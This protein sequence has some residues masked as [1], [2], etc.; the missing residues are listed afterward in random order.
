MNNIAAGLLLALAGVGSSFA[1]TITETRVDDTTFWHQSKA[2]FANLNTGHINSGILLDYGMEFA[3][4]ARFNGQDINDSNAVSFATLEQINSTLLSSQVAFSDHAP[5]PPATLYANLRAGARHNH[6]K[7]SGLLYEYQQLDSTQSAN[8]TIGAD[9]AYQDKYDETNTWLNPYKTGY[10]FAMALPVTWITGS[11]FTVELPENLWQTNLG[12]SVAQIEI[13]A[14]DGLG[15]RATA[16][17]GSLEV[18]YAA[19]GTKN[20][21]FR[22][23]V[24]GTGVFTGHG[25]VVVTQNATA[26]RNFTFTGTETYGDTVNSAEI[27]IDYAHN[28]GMLHKPLIIVEGIDP[29]DVLAPESQW[30]MTDVQA[31]FERDITNIQNNFPS[32]K[33]I[34]ELSS[35]EYDLI[36]VDW[37]NGT[38]YI[39]RNAALLKDLVKWVNDPAN[40]TGSEP[41]V[42]WGISMGGLVARYAIKDLEDDGYDHNI[43]LF[44]SDDAPQLGANVPLGAQAMCAHLK[45][46]FV[47]TGLLYQ[48]VANQIVPVTG[49][50]LAN[51]ALSLAERPA[52]AEMLINQYSPA[53]LALHNTWQEKLKQKGYPANCRNVVV[54]NG[55]ECAISQQ[56]NLNNELLSLHAQA[57]TG[58]ASDLLITSA[59]IIAPTLYALYASAATP[60]FG[61]LG[62]SPFLALLPGSSSI[63][64]DFDINPSLDGGYN[65]LYHGKLKYT[66]K[67]LWLVSISQTLTEMSVGQSGTA[68]LENGH[69]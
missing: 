59:S 5:M 64:A 44:I 25:T 57:N 63:Y 61:S 2:K 62:I 32:N 37:N 17:G 28:D 50:S 34:S 47:G 58:W 46:Y 18:V 19:G 14:D 67:L 22:V 56:L 39:E 6:L 42:V 23:S 11:S 51:A 12:G 10:A 45:S 38:D 69:C 49:S 36:Y 54:S 7:L 8:I 20:W 1:Q 35:G 30:G 29:G 65:Q 60:I 55:S 24:T 66:K 16:L 41:N 9:S 3:D 40:K 31:V 15:W 21:K 33:L 48:T 13:D 4:I 53:G 52:A 68:P 27:S 26:D 43:R